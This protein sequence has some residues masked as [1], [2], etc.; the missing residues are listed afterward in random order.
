MALGTTFDP[1]TFEL[2]KGLLTVSAILSFVAVSSILTSCCRLPR[3]KVGAVANTLTGL[4]GLSGLAML[5]VTVSPLPNTF[6]PSVR[7]QLDWSFFAALTGSLAQLL[8]GLFCLITYLSSPQTPLTT[9]STAGPD[10][11]PWPGSPS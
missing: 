1:A 8:S 4:I 11:T 10:A 9:D 2:A 7:P 3:F 5:G 6:H